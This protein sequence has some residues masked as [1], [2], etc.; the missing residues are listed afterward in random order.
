MMRL[1]NFSG[2]G[3]LPDWGMYET[4]GEMKCGSV[5]AV[6]IASLEPAS[7][8]SGAWATAVV[9][10]A[11]EKIHRNANRSMGPSEIVCGGSVAEVGAMGQCVRAPVLI[12]RGRHPETGR[13]RVEGPY[14]KVQRRCSGWD[15]PCCLY[16]RH[17]RACTDAV[18]FS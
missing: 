15:F 8:V 5:V 17:A 9:M 13:S 4:N 2:D 16:E 11:N 18:S 10:K 6:A 1:K 3:T 14:D 7:G 12:S